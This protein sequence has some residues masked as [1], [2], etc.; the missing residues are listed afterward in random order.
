[1]HPKTPGKIE[2]P[3]PH[4]KDLSSRVDDLRDNNI[5]K[6]KANNP[7]IQTISPQASFIWKLTIG[8]SFFFIT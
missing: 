4:H 7:K 2:G 8:I 3:F 6:Q 1:M 5:D